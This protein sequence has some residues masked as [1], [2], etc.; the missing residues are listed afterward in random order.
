M[1]YTKT[2]DYIGRKFGMVT[3]I[4]VADRK[5][6]KVSGECDCGTVRYFFLANLRRGLTKSC[7]CSFLGRPFDRHGKSN[8]PEFRTTYQIWNAMKNRCYLPRCVGWND[9][10]GRGITVCD[11]WL[12]SFDN[13]IEDMGVC[14]NGY[15]IERKDCNGNYEPLNCKWIPISKQAENTRRT[16]WILV[17]GEVLCAKRACEKAGVRYDLLQYRR[18]R[19]NQEAQSAFDEI[20]HGVK[21][22][23]PPATKLVPI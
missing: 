11:R 3:V 16:V 9:Y 7:G 21:I 22:V 18:H 1:A 20:R 4:G 5:V 19:M 17:D 8:S 10:G 13:F 15:S 23:Q 14:P 2:D 6:Q 12:S